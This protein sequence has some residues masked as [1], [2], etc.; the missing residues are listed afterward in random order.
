MLLNPRLVCRG[1]TFLCLVVH[2][3]PAPFAAP[4]NSPHARGHQ[5]PVQL[6]TQDRFPTT[7]RRGTAGGSLSPPP[8][9]KSVTVFP[10]P[11]SS[12]EKELGSLSA[13]TL[14]PAARGFELSN[15][16]SMSTALQIAEE[17][18]VCVEDQ[19]RELDVRLER[20]GAGGG[21]PAVVDRVIFL[22]RRDDHADHCFDQGQEKWDCGR[23]CPRTTRRTQEDH[24]A[25]AD[26][27]GGT[28]S[29]VGG[30]V[31]RADARI[32][33]PPFATA[34]GVVPLL[35]ATGRRPRAV[36]LADEVQTK[37]PSAEAEAESTKRKSDPGPVTGNVLPTTPFHRGLLVDTACWPSSLVLHSMLAQTP[38]TTPTPAEREPCSSTSPCSSSF[39]TSSSDVSP[40]RLR[41]TPLRLAGPI[42]RRSKTNKIRPSDEDSST[43]EPKPIGFGSSV[44]ESSKQSK[45]VLVPRPPGADPPWWSRPLVVMVSTP[46]ARGVLD[47]TAG[48]A[49]RASRDST[50][51]PKSTPQPPRS[52]AE[53]TTASVPP[54]AP[55]PSSAPHRDDHDHDPPTRIAGPVATTTTTPIAQQEPVELIKTYG[56]LENASFRPWL[57][58]A[59]LHSGRTT[60]PFGP[61]GQGGTTQPGGGVKLLFLDIDGVLNQHEIH[62]WRKVQAASA[63]ETISQPILDRWNHIAL[64]TTNPDFDNYPED[65]YLSKEEL[66]FARREKH[67]VCF[68]PRVPFPDVVHGHGMDFATGDRD[69]DFG[70]Q[71]RTTGEGQGGPRRQEVI[72]ANVGTTRGDLIVV[73]IGLG[74]GMSD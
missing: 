29:V 30:E 55:A 62:P 5:N 61:E 72:W 68:L 50:P 46:T 20:E 73:G 4:A 12:L 14:G 21:A 38:H 70:G 3:L 48:G 57:H 71:P 6:L 1:T 9:A 45:D 40:T 33:G 32:V 52:T 49:V 34:K 44:E 28:T 10:W 31:G 25:V 41:P 59:W 26:H 36:S 13:A 74:G 17:I 35:P 8:R 58:P 56:R 23:T 19:V 69:R 11:G 15:D 39:E 67:P 43:D 54:A 64:L 63:D 7:S 37:A 42:V 16:R 27:G 24:A 60:P 51:L 65:K 53:P 2:L 66:D 22:R 47:Q 18:G